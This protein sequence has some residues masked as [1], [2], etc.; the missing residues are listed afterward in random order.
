MTSYLQTKDL[1]RPGSTYILLQVFPLIAHRPETSLS[2]GCTKVQTEPSRELSRAPLLFRLAT[3]NHREEI[4]QSADAQGQ[5]P[6]RVDVSY[7]APSSCSAKQLSLCTPYSHNTHPVVLLVRLWDPGFRPTGQ[8]EALRRA[9]AGEPLQTQQAAL[10]TADSGSTRRTRR[11]RGR[12][13][14]AS[15]LS[16]L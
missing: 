9:E 7:V 16:L 4:G 6:Q 15:Q 12:S 14:P 11:R 13:P 5:R 10:R 3:Q 2:S 8:E 1:K